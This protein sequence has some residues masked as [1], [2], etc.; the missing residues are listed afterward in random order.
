[1]QKKQLSLLSILWICN[2][3]LLITYLIGWQSISFLKS[4]VLEYNNITSDPFDGAV[5]PI[6]YIPD[7]SKF[8]NTN[9]ARLFESFSIADFIEIP[10]YDIGL[11][12]DTLQQNTTATLLR[13]TYPVVYMGSYRGN[14]IEY[15]GS[16]PA[17]DIRAPI[18]TPVVS[19]ANG[20]VVKVKN[21]DTGDG[22][23]VIIRH[24]NID[25]NGVKETLYSGYEHLSEIIAVEGTK[26]KRGELLGKVG[27]T[28]I[29][30][31][32][33]LHFQIDKSTSPFHMY[34]PYTFQE[35]T[36]LG[37]DF[38]GAINVGL[39]KENA[40]RYTIN[41]MDFIKNNRFL[42]SAPQERNI[43]T[44]VKQEPLVV[45]SQIVADTTVPDNGNI[46]TVVPKS[47]NVI[48]PEVIPQPEEATSRVNI[49][50]RFIAD[51]THIFSDISTD[52]PFYSSTKYLSEAGVVQGYSDGGFHPND[53]VSRWEAILLYDRLFKN[54]TLYANIDFPFLDILPSDELAPALM[55]AFKENIVTGSNYFRPNDSLT[56]G[57]TITL[58]VRSSGMP[59]ET[60]K[61]SLFY[62]VNI[63]NSHAKYINTFARYLGIPGGNFEPNKSITR[64]ELAKILYAFDQKR[65]KEGN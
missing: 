8:E 44:I 14:Y 61:Y 4:S 26:I 63:N 27:M 11:L 42:G 58:L 24:D 41:P 36:D 1:M 6:A 3:I 59:I 13:Y 29:T 51:T 35:A 49:S 9:K 18:G 37:L 20:V 50:P 25:V 64:G 39:G 22:K 31:T 34:W 21:T 52:S 12:S 23:Y 54:N 7:W 28:G 48:I 53:F 45:S 33:H 5:S 40:I 30:T 65:K 2:L 57:E 43:A 32:P 16:H 17:V 19:V 47:E 46:I 15:N 38:F 55:R 10:E 60:L 56:R 62:D